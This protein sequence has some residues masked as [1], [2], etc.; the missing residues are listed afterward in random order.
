MTVVVRPALTDHVTGRRI[1]RPVGSS[2]CGGVL[3]CPSRAAIAAA[4]LLLRTDPAGTIPR[5]A[6]A[7][8][9]IHI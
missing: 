7:L 2:A 8:S 3:S 1:G 6:K 9:L 5:T 4:V